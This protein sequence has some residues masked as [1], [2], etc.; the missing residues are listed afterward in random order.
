[1]DLRTIFS[2]ILTVPFLCP[3]PLLSPAMPILAFDVPALA[4]QAAHA[5]FGWI[6]HQDPALL[7]S[8]DG[9][10][11][12]LCPRCIGLHAGFLFAALL[13]V[14]ML[15][16]RPL[17]AR[18]IA[19]LLAACCVTLAHWLLCRGGVLPPDTAWRLATG[20]ASGAAGGLLFAEYR[21][22]R[23]P[24]PRAGL[25]QRAVRL[26]VL[27]GVVTG[28]GIAAAGGLPRALNALLLFAVAANAAALATSFLFLLLPRPSIHHD[29]QPET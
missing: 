18:G 23:F 29:V 6:C 20:L 19:L 27:A 13:S 28:A 11:L 24:A 12:W 22:R 3:P 9:A 14:G 16:R 5:A 1:M 8:I 2:D 7:T 10:P 21:R 4:D 25:M 17:S 26:L 15:Q